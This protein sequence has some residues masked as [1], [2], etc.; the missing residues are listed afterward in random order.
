MTLRSQKLRQVNAQADSL[1][2]GMGWSP[3]DLAKPQILVESCEGE[4]H[5][6]SYHLGAAGGGGQERPPFP[7][8]EASFFFATDIC[9][10]IAQS[11]E[12]MDFSLPSREI[13]AH[14][15]E[16]H[17]QSHQHDGMVLISTCDKA[18]PAHLIASARVNIP[19]VLLPGG[20][21]DI[22]PGGLTENDVAGA[23]IQWQKGDITEERFREISQGACPSCGA[24]QF[25]GTASTMQ[26]LTEALGMCLPGAALSPPTPTCSSNMP[27]RRGGNCT[28]SRE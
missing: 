3:E 13:L 25:M 10:G 5:S 15:V 28:S 8:Y 26:V 22:G 11:H 7:R 2:L 6:G 9:D 24:C 18:I 17:A 4:T 14:L 1:K 12:G 16:I 19:A 20:S 27:E 23:F 21:M